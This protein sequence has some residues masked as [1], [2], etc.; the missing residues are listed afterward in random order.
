MLALH[1][2]KKHR[3]QGNG[4]SVDPNACDDRKHRADNAFPKTL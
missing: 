1:R 4:A 2:C 3:T